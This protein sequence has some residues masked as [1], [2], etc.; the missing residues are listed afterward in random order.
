MKWFLAGLALVFASLAG[1]IAAIVVGYRQIIG[2]YLGEAPR[3]QRSVGENADARA[4]VA[5]PSP[6]PK[7]TPSKAVRR[8][9]QPQQ[10]GAF[11][12]GQRFLRRSK[13]KPKLPKARSP[14]PITTE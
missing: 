14:Q 11:P 13:A 1:G 7:T 4:N 2:H 9:L 3:R 10:N 5:A 8:L 6:A 12:D